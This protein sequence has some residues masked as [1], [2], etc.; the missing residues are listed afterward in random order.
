MP[1][2]E[3]LMH[4]TPAEAAHLERQWGAPRRNALGHGEYAFESGALRPVERRASGGWLPGY[5]P[6]TKQPE[7]LKLTRTQTPLASAEDYYN[8]GAGPEH[9]FFKENVVPNQ[10]AFPAQPTG[11]VPPAGTSGAGTGDIAGALGLALAAKQ[12]WDAI[13]GSFDK[14]SATGT[15]AGTPGEGGGT[16]GTKGLTEAGSLSN[17]VGMD[18]VGGALAGVQSLTSKEGKFKGTLSGASSGMSLGGWPGAI[19]G[20][21]L[22]YAQEGGVKDANPWDASGFSGTTMDKAWQDENIARLASN[23]AASVASKLGVKSDSAFGKILDPS[24][25]FSKHG[26]EK[27]NMKAFTSQ[28]QLLEGP[29]GE[30]ALPDGKIITKDQLQHLAG[31]WYGATYH[32]DGDQEGWQKKFQDAVSEIYGYA[33]GGALRSLGEFDTDSAG[34]RH[35]RGPGTGRSDSIPAQ[36]SDGEYVLTAE[37]VSLLGDGSNEAGARKLDEFR[38][39]LRM[40]KGGALARGK[41]SPNA[42]APMEYLAEGAR[43]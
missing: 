34:S 23:P 18:D 35:V 19:V 9:Q 42:K 26:D 3:V 25:F 21:A 39:A 31:T 40:H 15:D 5:G 32:P 12:G 24:G 10:P 2:R 17:G 14:G 30:I 13:K 36:L 20:G 8:Y 6:T 27:R 29:N 41:I 28:Y 33:Q 11:A 7:P 16:G 4:L 37:D 1:V 38:Q 43:R 22:G